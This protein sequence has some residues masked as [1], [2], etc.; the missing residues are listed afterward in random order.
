MAQEGS[1]PPHPGHYS[2]AVRFAHADRF[3]HVRWKDGAC[4]ADLY[5][6]AGT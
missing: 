2:C 6:T 1:A 4:A 3:F 5:G